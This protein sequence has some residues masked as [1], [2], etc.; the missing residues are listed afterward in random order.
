MFEWVESKNYILNAISNDSQCNDFS[1]SEGV[2]VG[3]HI[4]ISY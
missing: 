3:I 4:L 2:V 1:A